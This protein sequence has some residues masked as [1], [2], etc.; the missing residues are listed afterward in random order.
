MAGTPAH[1]AALAAT[2]ASS[3]ESTVQPDLSRL[4]WA[5]CGGA[6]L[7]PEIVR[8]A[9]ASL[10]VRVFVNGLGMTEAAGSVTRTAPDAAPEV[11]AATIGYPMPWLETRVVDAASG[12]DAA[13]GVA[14][15]LWI[16]GPTLMKGYFRE[17]DATSEAFARDGWLRTGDVVRKRPEG[18]FE[19][20]GRSKEVFTVGGFNVYPAE[21]ERVLA[22][23]PAVADSCVVGVP[24]ERLGDVPLAFVRLRDGAATAAEDLAAYCAERLANYKVPRVFELT[25]ELPVGPSGKVDRLALRARAAERVRSSAHLSRS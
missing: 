24:D 4:R 23:H 10:G 2:I 20:V 6:A 19:F 25:R 22:A 13:E 3:A 17:P 8:R 11:T 9:R 12:E 16:R 7:T 1:Y 5:L 18:D 21:V 14:G 15:E